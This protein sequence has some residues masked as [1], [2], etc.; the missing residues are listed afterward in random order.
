MQLG[1]FNV[2]CVLCCSLRSTCRV[3]QELASAC[4]RPHP[5]ALGASAAAQHTQ[6]IE[7]THLH[8]G[9]SSTG[10]LICTIQ[11]QF[12]MCIY[13]E[14]C[15]PVVLL[16]LSSQDGSCDDS[17][18]SS[19]FNR[20]QKSDFGKSE[21][22]GARLDFDQFKCLKVDF[23]R[24]RRTKFGLSTLSARRS[25]FVQQLAAWAVG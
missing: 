21:V 12:I 9:S 13:S 4:S 16:Q 7:P 10:L 23:C 22:F 3:L 18:T 5:A 2:L 15:Y 8:P 24:R 6:H 1:C 19:N 17:V 14:L 25:S 11:F 20:L